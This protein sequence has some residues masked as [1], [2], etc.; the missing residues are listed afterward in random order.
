MVR[1]PQALLNNTASQLRGV[2]ANAPRIVDHEGNSVGRV[3]TNE[4]STSMSA[5]NQTFAFK[6]LKGTADGDPGESELITK[7]MLRRQFLT[8]LQS[9]ALNHLTN[10]RR[11][12]A[13]ACPFKAHGMKESPMA[14]E[15]SSFSEIDTGAKDVI[16][17][18]T[19][20]VGD[21]NMY[22]SPGI[23]VHHRSEIREMAVSATNPGCQPMRLIVAIAVTAYWL[24][25]TTLAA[26]VPAITPQPPHLQRT[27]GAFKL[28]PDSVI[29]TDAA[30]QDIGTFLAERIRRSPGPACSGLSQFRTRR[31]PGSSEPAKIMS[32]S[33]RPHLPSEPA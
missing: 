19:S 18:S 24:A 1:R 13:I 11:N 7:G 15:K 4:G 3:W 22:G 23:F 29:A 9:A 21:Y 30:S 31:R 10:F 26:T 28:S 6:K 16:T 27:E 25:A 20:R 2:E 5:L 8:R 33:V 12:P 17:T 32:K 14:K